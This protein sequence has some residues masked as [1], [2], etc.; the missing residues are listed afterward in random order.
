MNKPYIICHMMASA[1]GRIDC[2][3]TAK[4]SGVKEYYAALE[5]LKLNAALSGKITAQ[6][7]LAEPGTFFSKKEESVSTE[8]F[9][10]KI[11]SNYYN[12]V[13]DSCGTL[14]WQQNGGDNFPLIVITSE[15]ASKEYL[16]Y[17][18]EKNISWIACGEKRIDLVRASEI[19]W[20]IFGVKRMGIVGGGKINA[21]FLSAGLLDEISLL[22]APGIDGRAG[23]ATIFDG[24][25]FGD[26]PIPLILK[27]VIPYDNGA[28]LLQYQTQNNQTK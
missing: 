1:D 27:N 26:E 4:L 7:E 21:A 20:K 22:I 9:S 24:D 12:I 14:L 10:K 15:T 11:D 2:N 17:L 16:S 6:L 8:G 25:N 13:T 3:M 23:T 5:N 18:D 28:V 19:L